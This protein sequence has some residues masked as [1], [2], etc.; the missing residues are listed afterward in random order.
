M[1]KALFT[2]LLLLLSLP[3]SGQ[4]AQANG[5]P[6]QPKKKQVASAERPKNRPSAAAAREKKP[7]PVATPVALDPEADRKR[8]D[9]ALEAPTTMEKARLLRAFIDEF[10][11]SKLREEAFSYLITARA[12]VGNDLVQAGDLTAGIASYKLAVDEA[13]VPIPDR[14]FGDV[15][16]KIPATLF[17]GKERAAALEL[18]TL[19]EKKVAAYPKQ[20]LGVAAFYLGTENGAEARRVAEAVLAL[21]PT[22]VAAYQA[23]GLAHRLNFDLKDAAE[24]YSKAIELDPAS[25][26]AKRSLAEM[27]RSLGKPEAAAAIYRELLAANPSDSAARQGLVLSLFDA[28]QQKEAESEFSALIQAEPRNFTLLAGVAY[29]YAANDQGAKAVEYS[30]KAIDIEP[31]YIWSHIVL[32]RGLMKESKPLEAERVLL[33]ARQYGNFPTL[34]YEIA[35]ARLQAGLYREAAEE[36]RKS[37]S[38]KDGMVGTRLGGRI[39]KEES[40][41]IDLISYERRASLLEPSPAENAENAAKLKLL[42]ELERAVERSADEAELTNLA[43][44]FIK[45]SDKMRIHRQLYVANL[46]LRKNVAVGKVAELLKSSLGSAESGLDVVAPGAAV[47]ASELYESR[48]AAFARNEVIVIPEV[49]RQTLSAIL[50]GRI[51]E[52]AGWTAF[53]QREYPEAVVR[54]RRAISVLPD[55]SAW[56]RSSMWRLGA[57]LEA[58]GKDAEALESYIKSYVTDRPSSARYGVI[59]ALYKRVNGSSEGLEEKIGPSPGPIVAVAANT[60][61]ADPS[62]SGETQAK[63]PVQTAEKRVDASPDNNTP[64]KE[65]SKTIEDPVLPPITATAA[66]ETK[67]PAGEKKI[68]DPPTVPATSEVKK[69]VAEPVIT[70][71][72]PPPVQKKE[73]AVEPP[74][75]VTESVKMPQVESEKREPETTPSE[76][77]VNTGVKGP[78]PEKKKDGSDD[79]AATK[80]KEAEPLKNAATEKP[81]ADLN[82][83][84]KEAEPGTDKQAAARPPQTQG[85]EARSAELKVEPP[86]PVD[87]VS[88]SDKEPSPKSEAD[89]S[90]EGPVNLLRDPFARPAPDASQPARNPVAKPEV[91]VNDPYKDQAAANPAGT[92]PGKLMPIFGSTVIKTSGENRPAKEV[93]TAEPDQKPSPQPGITRSRIVEGKEIVADQ[94]CSLQLSQASI[95]LLAGGGSF[96][97]KVTIDG[98]GEIGSVTAS[99]SDP[100]DVEVRPEPMAEGVTGRRFFVIKSVSE[101][102]GIFH[103]NFGSPCGKGEVEVHV[104]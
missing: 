7:E 24:A 45:G 97:L 22:S 61:G 95:M 81:A 18:A 27:D 92:E 76:A 93:K 49:P 35:S 64:S 58:D 68:E 50:R 55:K 56:W 2:V 80:A 25:A 37:F 78:P 20:L 91:I 9:A 53:Q 54:L 104:R 42:L 73:E 19:I 103:V 21:D 38:I 51:E 23:L 40:T 5:K 65:A 3:A 1:N 67:Q 57:A 30:Q 70:E 48:T 59:E 8:Y 13:P 10:P 98:P 41:F 71:K 16:M 29:W 62:A 4:K 96:G 89:P 66:P 44:E 52:L 31:R 90:K 32:A 28:G 86:V 79:P 94:P 34:D 74:K 83:T 75:E 43:D 69:E 72:E 6:S 82:S 88:P 15:V 87:T 12:V 46:F 17:Y 63:P 33:K 47:M 99:S 100:A 85:T 60:G 26:S 11:E 84:T 102:T 77:V 14:M 36:L 39:F 101:K